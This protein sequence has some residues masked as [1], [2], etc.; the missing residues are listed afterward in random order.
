MSTYSL[1]EFRKFEEQYFLGHGKVSLL[2]QD[3]SL[4]PLKIFRDIMLMEARPTIGVLYLGSQID[5]V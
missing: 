2:F 4:N 3:M 1:K 5:T